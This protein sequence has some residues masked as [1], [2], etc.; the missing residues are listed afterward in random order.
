M[1][2]QNLCV[3][4]IQQGKG[5]GMEKDEAV[6][7]ADENNVQQSK[8]EDW[9]EGCFKENYLV[10]HVCPVATGK[11]CKNYTKCKNMSK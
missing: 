1:K 6:V 10:P 2:L 9:V 7:T 5:D 11:W 4:N 8:E 3:I